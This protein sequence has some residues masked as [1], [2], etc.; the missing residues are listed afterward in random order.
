MYNPLKIFKT[1]EKTTHP[2][3]RRLVKAMDQSEQDRLLA[4]AD[5]LSPKGQKKLNDKLS[6]YYI[7]IVRKPVETR[8]QMIDGFIDDY[9]KVYPLG[10]DESKNLYMESVKKRVV[11]VDKKTG[12]VVAIHDGIRAAGKASGVYQGTISYIC[13]H[14]SKGGNGGYKSAGGCYWYFEEEWNQMQAAK[15]E[16]KEQTSAE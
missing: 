6:E 9:L 14:K 7:I 4:K 15:E 16:N 13:N 3:L 1:M 8:I 5:G 12:V 11:Q 10:C 2:T